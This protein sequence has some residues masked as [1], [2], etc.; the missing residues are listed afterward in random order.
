MDNTITTQNINDDEVD[1]VD[2]EEY[3]KEGKRVP[4]AKKYVIRIDN[5]R[6]TVTTP[7]I[8]GRELLTLAGKVPVERFM[9]SQK[10]H[11]GKVKKIELDETV[12]FRAP[13]I[14]RFM[15]LPLDQQEG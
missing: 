12:D 13:G 1:S 9:L 5:T 6:Y 8:K 7:S 3:G 2:L 4:K 10:L 11:G 15:T 14:E